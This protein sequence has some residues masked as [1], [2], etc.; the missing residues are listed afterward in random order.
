[1]A[2]PQT[3]SA[4]ELTKVPPAFT[5]PPPFLQPAESSLAGAQ[6]TGDQEL[7]FEGPMPRQVCPGMIG[8]FS[9]G[10][11]Y[12]TAREYGYCDKRSGTCFCN[13]GYED[14]DCSSCQVPIPSGCMQ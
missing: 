11:Y 9:D 7:L 14:I 8:P 2:T 6:D 3:T 10:N 1:M 5:S 4:R 13:V 12:C